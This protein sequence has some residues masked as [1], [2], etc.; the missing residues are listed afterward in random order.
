M[1]VEEDEWYTKLLN[2]STLSSWAVDVPGRVWSYKQGAGQM[3]YWHQRSVGGKGSIRDWGVTATADGRL[4]YSKPYWG[5]GWTRESL[6]EEVKRCYRATHP[7]FLRDPLPKPPGGEWRKVDILSAS[8]N[9]GTVKFGDTGEI[10][11]IIGLHLAPLMDAEHSYV[12]VVPNNHD[13]YTY[14]VLEIST[15]PRGMIN[16]MRLLLGGE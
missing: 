14:T 6:Y 12:R 10:A 1:S 7:A 3:R 5:M 4:V 13:T 16:R 11:N 15:E 9:A 8:E 2:L